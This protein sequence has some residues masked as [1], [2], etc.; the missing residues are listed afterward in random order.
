[1]SVNCRWCN[2]TPTRRPVF[3]LKCRSQSQM[4]CDSVTIELPARAWLTMPCA[5]SE[6]AMFY[7]A[8][9][10]TAYLTKVIFL[11]WAKLSVLSR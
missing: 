5:S 8:A 10:P 9:S 11:D 7:F 6:E 3:A 4:I 1:M 2:A